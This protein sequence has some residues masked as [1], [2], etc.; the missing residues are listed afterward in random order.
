MSSTPWR[1]S[2]DTQRICSG[3]KVSAAIPSCVPIAATLDLEP[4]CWQG[5]SRQLRW[6]RYHSGPCHGTVPAAGRLPE[7]L[8]VVPSKTQTRDG[9]M[10]LG[11]TLEPHL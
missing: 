11:N 4:A 6:S 7:L 10:V 3:S 1:N 5:C 8:N 2:A 9:R